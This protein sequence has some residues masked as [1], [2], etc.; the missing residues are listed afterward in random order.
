MDFIISKARIIN[1]LLFELLF[2]ILAEFST[3]IQRLFDS[4]YGS[5]GPIASN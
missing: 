1:F 4:V 3:V 2:V 5:T